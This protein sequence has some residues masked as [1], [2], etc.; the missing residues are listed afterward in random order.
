VEE[1]LQQ[2]GEP[3]QG[4]EPVEERDRQRQQRRP[5]RIADVVAGEE[6]AIGDPI[7]GVAVREGI[8]EVEV[9]MEEGEAGEE[10]ARRAEPGEEQS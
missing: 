5:G 7:V 3:G 2:H 1:E 10:K 6:E 4:I 8:V 9:V